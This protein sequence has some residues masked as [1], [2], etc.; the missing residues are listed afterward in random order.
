MP[1]QIDRTHAD[2][3][4]TVNMELRNKKQTPAIHTKVPKIGN[5]CILEKNSFLLE[6]IFLT[7]NRSKIKKGLMSSKITQG[8][9]P[10]EKVT[11]TN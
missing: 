6:T 5:K 1:T 11:Y 9:A 4:A 8:L 3:I 10:R 2:A 7:K